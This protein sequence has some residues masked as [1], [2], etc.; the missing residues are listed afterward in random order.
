MMGIFP[1]Y[2]E[3]RKVAKREIPLVM[4]KRIEEIPVFSL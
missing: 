2:A 1:P 3:Y 4:M